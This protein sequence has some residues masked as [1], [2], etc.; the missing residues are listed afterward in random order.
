V[1]KASLEAREAKNYYS[2]LVLHGDKA[3]NSASNDG[4]G[5][6]FPL[7]VYPVTVHGSSLTL[8]KT[9]EK[10]WLYLISLP[11]GV[12]YFYQVVYPHDANNCRLLITHLS[13]HEY[14]AAFSDHSTYPTL[15]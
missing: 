2:M 14:A 3:S 6:G 5:F 7:M 12:Y 8:I 1:C 15:F 9:N 11:S 4:G 10:I 13:K